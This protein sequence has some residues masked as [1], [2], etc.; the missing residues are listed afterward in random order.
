MKKRWCVVWFGLGIFVGVKAKTYWEEV[1]IDYINDWLKTAPHLD[2]ADF[3]R[4]KLT[5][6]DGFSFSAQASSTHYCYPRV[7]NAA[8][9]QS[10]E[11]G[12]PSEPDPILMKYAEDDQFAT[13]TIY[14]YVPIQVVNRLIR[15]HG[16]ILK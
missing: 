9:Y 10:V 4:E 3:V 11:I 2:S 12:F 13:D 8:K 7:D 1:N 6:K 16:G 15:K 5:C 14:P